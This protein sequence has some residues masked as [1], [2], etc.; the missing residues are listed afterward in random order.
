M[1]CTVFID[2]SGDAG[3]SSIRSKTQGGS[4][5]YFTMGAVVLQP[6]T[7]IAAR[8]LLDQLQEDFKRPKRWRHAT[9]LNHSQK[10]HF[11]RKLSALNVRY[12]GVISYK[13]TLGAYA[14]NIDWEPDKFYNK[15]AKYLLE[16]VGNYL[17]AIGGDLSEPQIVFEERNHDYDAMI[18]YLGKVKE[19]PIYEHSKSLASINP[20]G[21]SSKKKTEEDLLRLADLVSHALYCCVNKTPDNFG[22]VEPRY[23]QELSKRFAADKTGR[24]FGTGLK[25]IH[26]LDDLQ[27]DKDALAAFSSLRAHPLPLRSAS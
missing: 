2:E 15:C 9:D 26:K 14:E 23:V 10:L 27:L 11:C 17:S 24:V 1:P 6:A 19:N 25:A 8:K 13:P 12:F 16:R 21:I 3:V 18:R 20:F 5:E 4:S 22:I 7:M